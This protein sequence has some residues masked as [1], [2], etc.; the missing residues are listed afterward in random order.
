[1]IIAI[2]ESAVALVVATDVAVNLL[3]AAQN[4]RYLLAAI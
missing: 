3:N 1:V 2:L 4:K